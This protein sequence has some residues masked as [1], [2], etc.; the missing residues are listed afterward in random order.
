MVKDYFKLYKSNHHLIVGYPIYGP[1]AYLNPND[2]N[3]GIKLIT[4]SY[5]IRS[6]TK[7]TTLANGTALSVTQYGPDV[8]AK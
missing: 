7:R 2:A 3:S 5:K 8:S 1:Y 6:I 4:P